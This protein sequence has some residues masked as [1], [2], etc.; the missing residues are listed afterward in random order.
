MRRTALAVDAHA[1]LYPTHR[2]EAWLDAALA[3]LARFDDGASVERAVVLADTARAEGYRRLAR[4]G[5][6]ASVEIARSRDPA[7]PILRIDHRGERLHVLPGRQ[8]VT[9]ERLEV[10]A[11]G[12][13]ASLPDGLDLAGALAAAREAGAL[14]VLPWSPGKWLGGRGRL[15]AA[16]LERCSRDELLVADSALR[17]R[18]WP[19][20][21]LLRRA[22]RRGI[23]LIAGSDP[24]PAAGEEVHAGRYGVLG[25][26]E[27]SPEEMRELVLALLAGG[28]ALAGSRCGPIEVL[29]RLARHRRERFA[30]AAPS[31]R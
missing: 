11:L 26:V 31:G 18:G 3:N 6:L 2:L 20:P 24:L 10:L 28:G 21:R 12:T 14:A 23:S 7:P 8:V 4:A 17:P 5:A 27:G 9:R 22:R 29:R 1:H 13:A 16:A 30:P 19:L 25:A 15:V